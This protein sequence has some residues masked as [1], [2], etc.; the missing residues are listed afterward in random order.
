LAITELKDFPVAKKGKDASNK[1]ESVL[2][3]KQNASRSK[4]IC[5]GDDERM[6]IVFR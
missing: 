5:V 4:V 2:K 6:K 1:G 3:I